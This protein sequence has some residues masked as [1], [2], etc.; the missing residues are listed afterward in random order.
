MRRYFPWL[1]AACLGTLLILSLAANSYLFSLANTYYKSLNAV[2]LNPLGL[3]YY[4]EKS[5]SSATGQTT[6]VFFGDSRA[7]QWPVPAG[8]ANIHFLNRGIGAQTSAQISGRLPVHLRPL[9]PNIVIVQMGINDIKTIPLFPDQKEEIIQNCQA[10]LQAVVSQS[11]A[12]GATVIVTTIFPTGSYPPERRLYW[13]DEINTAVTEINT[14]IHS[15]A[16]EDVLILDAWAYLRD[17]DGRL[18]T[19]YAADEL[20]LNQ[21][22]YA[23]LNE[24]LVALLPD[25]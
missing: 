5:I 14:F 1:L 25:E 22:G 24:A 15:L 3:N 20:H 12:M 16:A 23:L 8:I 21:A 18:H 4:P 7:A 6:A 2:R 13:S 10:N 11:Q 19:A 17:E 9:Q